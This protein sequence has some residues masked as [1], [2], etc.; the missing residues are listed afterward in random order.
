MGASARSLRAAPRANPRRVVSRRIDVAAIRREEIVDAAARVVASRGIQNLSL[1]AIETEAGMS[2]GQLTYYFR[3]KEQI[4]LALFD[5]TVRRMR[6]RMDAGDSDAC[7]ADADAWDL[8]SALL[9]RLLLKPVPADFTRLQYSFLA[10]T[11][12]RDDFR[13]RLASLYSD[14]RDQMAEGFRASAV[15]ERGDPRLLASFVQALLHG[16]VLQLQ[17]DPAAFNRR[18]THQLCLELLG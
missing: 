15:A 5:R 12:F 1:S 14:W 18:A 9:S 7:R 4:L 13:R 16:L 6:E 3:T 11:G 2:R 17:A 8:I 10:Q